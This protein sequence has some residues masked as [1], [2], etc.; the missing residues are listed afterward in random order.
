MLGEH[1]IEG[2]SKAQP[3]IALSVGEPELYAALK[4]SREASG[5][6]A[7]LQYFGYSARGEVW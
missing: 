6:V 3:L 2:W 5:L 7:L 1:A 4:A